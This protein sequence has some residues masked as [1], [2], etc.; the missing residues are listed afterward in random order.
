[1]AL[2][3]LDILDCSIILMKATRLDTMLIIIVIIILRL[4]DFFF[5]RTKSIS[6]ELRGG[7]G[8]EMN[9]MNR[10]REETC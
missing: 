6:L 10:L 8:S 1:M 5:W 3:L 7:G 9:R 2:G 4:I